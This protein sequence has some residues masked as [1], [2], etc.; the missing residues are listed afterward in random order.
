MGK[1][2]KQSSKPSS[3]WM[4]FCKGVLLSLGVYLLGQLLL[5][6][7]LVKGALGEGTAFPIIA[8]LCVLAAALGGLL[9]ARRSPWGP[10]PGGLLCAALF[11]GLLVAGGALWWEGITWTGRG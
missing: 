8:C 11:A 1:A 9:P 6:G 7:L 2:K 4:P 5:A 10:L 3:A